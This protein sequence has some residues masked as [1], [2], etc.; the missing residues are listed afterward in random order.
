MKQVHLLLISLLLY[1]L[2]GLAYTN[3]SPYS[4]CGGDP[5]NCIDPTGNDIVVLNYTE[6]EHLAMLIQNEEGKWQYYSVN[7]NNVVLPLIKEHTGGREFNDVA[8]GSWDSP[9]E[10]L[11]SSYNVRLKIVRMINP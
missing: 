4:Y 6:G 2:N 3:L 8:V 1:P 9:Q 11:D 5:V 7:G 10:F